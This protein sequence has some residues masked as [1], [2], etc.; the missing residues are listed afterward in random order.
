MKIFELQENLNVFAKDTRLKLMYLKQIAN[1]E[2]ENELST[3][4]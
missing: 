3:Q 2:T 1:M 4:K